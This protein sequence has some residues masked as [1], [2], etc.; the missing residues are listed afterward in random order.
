[1]V[2]PAPVT[3][4]ILKNY[5][6]EFNPSC[7]AWLS[8]ILGGLIVCQGYLVGVRAIAPGAVIFTLDDGFDVL[9]VKLQNSSRTFSPNFG[10]YVRVTG[11]CEIFRQDLQIK[12]TSISLLE[13][14]HD[15]SWALELDDY[16][17][18]ASIRRRG[19]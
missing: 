12:A 5:R 18:A 7:P 6:S 8:R 11:R 14:S 4:Y 16:W 17:R 2:D 9:L 1:M 19:K 3:V 10:D 13:D 15:M